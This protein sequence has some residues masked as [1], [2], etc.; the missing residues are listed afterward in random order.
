M[1]AAAAADHAVQP[2]RLEE[3]ATEVAR[4][5]SRF[6]PGATQAAFVRALL[7]GRNKHEAGSGGAV[8]TSSPGAAAAGAR[9]LADGGNAIDAACAAALVLTVTD[10]ANSGIAGRCHIVIRRRDGGPIV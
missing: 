5:E 2:A 3:I 7:D 10:P 9:V 1:F 6:G 4:I 8:A